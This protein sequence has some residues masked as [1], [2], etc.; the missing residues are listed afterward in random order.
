MLHAN[1]SKYRKSTFLE[2]FMEDYNKH[3]SNAKMAV[4]RDEFLEAFKLLQTNDILA[5]FGPNKLNPQFKLQHS[6]EM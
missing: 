6:V 3:G 4:S 1:E 5:M 2:Q